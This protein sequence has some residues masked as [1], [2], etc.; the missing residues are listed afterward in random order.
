MLQYNQISGKTQSMPETFT[1]ST[2]TRRV[3]DFEKRFCFDLIFVEKP[4]MTYT[5]QALSE[6]DRK[7]WLNAMDGKEP[8]HLTPG[9]STKTDEYCL[10]EIGFDFVKTCIEILE[11]RGLEEEGLYRVGGVSTKI[12]KLISVGLDRSK[13]ESERRQ[14]FFNGSNMDISETKTIASALKHFLRHLNEPI[15]TYRLHDA[16]ITAASK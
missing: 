10:D 7:I 2:C 12:T 5:F 16:F 15:M 13:T 4:G 8:Q 6:E 3:S 14:A 1:L 11:E 9:Q